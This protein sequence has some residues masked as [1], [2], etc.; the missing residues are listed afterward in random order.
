M[1]S[2]SY[3]PLTTSSGAGQ[4]ESA[5]VRSIVGER[6]LAS[7]PQPI[8]ELSA[9]VIL[10]EPNRPGKLTETLFWASQK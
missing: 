8:A 5:L 10:A 9:P 3:L 1:I 7:V 4:A 2:F 6:A